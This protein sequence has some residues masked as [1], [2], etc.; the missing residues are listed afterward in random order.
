MFRDNYNVVR[1]QVLKVLNDNFDPTSI[2]G[3]KFSGDKYF[4][5]NAVYGGTSSYAFVMLDATDEITKYRSRDAVIFDYTFSVE[6]YNEF[7]EELGS[8]P[9]PSYSVLMY[10]FDLIYN[11]I[12]LFNNDS[13]KVLNVINASTTHEKLIEPGVTKWMSTAVFTL[14]IGFNRIN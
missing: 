4:T 3:L 12:N 11:H 13:F 6:I 7:K 10:V 8:N 2:E 9:A 14:T 1:A 5:L